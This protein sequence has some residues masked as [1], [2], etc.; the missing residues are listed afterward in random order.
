MKTI[1]RF[2]LVGIVLA[3]LTAGWVYLYT[4]SRA[5][6]GEKQNATL[7]LLKDLKQTD[8]NWNTDVLK[9][10][11]EIIRSYDALVRPLRTFSDILTALDREAARLK[12]DDLKKDVAD[13][14]AAIDKKAALIDRFKAQNSLL[15]NSL[16]YA[17]TAY[18]D[19]QEQMRSQRDM[20]MS[21]G[22]KLMRDMPNAFNELEKT[23]TANKADG[24]NAHV[25]A[26]IAK[27]REK[28]KNAK[29]A[30]A[31]AKNAFT[32]VS[33]DS[34]VSTLVGEALRYNSV[35]DSETAEVLK[36]GIAKM[37]EATPS[38]PASVQESVENLMSHLDE[39]GRASCRERV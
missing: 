13:I 14:R 20:G 36:T 17:P 3:G 19:I 33:L 1:L 27:L 21:Q 26:A 8:S 7:G 32:L 11:T 34:D 22:S 4:N 2:L 29:Q 16:R 39:I 10:Q 15:K 37:R 12:D 35:P 30:D 9:S 6:D 28:M 24:N 23:L 38:Y 5:V 18:K 25:D 31:A